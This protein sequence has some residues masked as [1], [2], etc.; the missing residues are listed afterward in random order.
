MERNLRHKVVTTVLRSFDVK[1]NREMETYLK[2]DVRSKEGFA[3]F[4]F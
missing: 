3:F 1:G 2:R 4:S